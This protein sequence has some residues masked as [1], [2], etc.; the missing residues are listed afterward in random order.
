MKLAL[1]VILSMEQLCELIMALICAV[2]APCF[3][4]DVYRGQNYA[5]EEI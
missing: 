3:G 5:N 4:F 2:Q 1:H